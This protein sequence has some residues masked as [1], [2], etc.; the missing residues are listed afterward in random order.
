VE[1]A[2]AALLRLAADP[3]E[4]AAPAR[5]EVARAL[6][7]IGVEPFD[8]LLVPL[9]FDPDVDVAREAV[10]SVGRLERNPALFIAPLVTLLRHRLLKKDARAVLVAYGDAVV[11][12]L[13]HFLRDPHEDVWVRRHVPATL[14]QLPGSRALD[15]LLDTLSDGDGFLRYKAITAIEALHR[16]RPGLAIRR[17]PVETL[18]LG[19]SLRYFEALTLH[20]NLVRQL[21]GGDVPL[22][23]RALDEKQQRARAR[24]FRLLGLLYAQA[25]ISTAWV[26]LERG[27]VRRR[28]SASEYLDNVLKGPLRTRVLLMVDDMPADE[29]IRRVNVLF[30]TRPRDVDDTLAQLVHDEDD[31][32]AA[33]AIHLAAARGPG[34]LADDL[35]YVASHRGDSYAGEA[36]TWALATP[37]GAVGA[38]RLQPLPVV[39]LA[40]RLKRVALFDYVSVDELFR[41][42]GTA[43]Q[44]RYDRG[45]V[46]CP[47]G[48]PPDALQFLL[49]GEATDDAGTAL[50]APALVGFDAMVTRTPVAAEVRAADCAVT[51]SL[52]HD[53]FVTVL[54]DNVEIAHGFFRMLLDARGR[55]AV[56]V[57]P[58]ELP[59]AIRRRGGDPLQPTDALLLLQACPLLAGATPAQLMRVATLARQATLVPGVPVVRESDEAAIHIVVSGALLVDRRGQPPAAAHP[60]DA[61]GMY[62]TLARGHAAAT[63]TAATAGTALRITGRDLFDT[64]ADD[65]DLLERL[66]GA[67]VGS[68]PPAELESAP[69]LGDGSLV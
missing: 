38:D 32:I 41:I 65:V 22:V 4:S 8:Q 11:E 37:L 23:V 47:G 12:P 69:R 18:A 34:P 1:A 2:H 68:A 17:E 27:D 13:A 16:A 39:E 55:A 57:V 19:E 24:V 62:D 63:V 53:E 51:L 7:R 26:A 20:A 48:R 50:R 42:A 52:T 35:R 28:A 44:I 66:L 40:H 10:R 9:L 60:G 45:R 25:D 67:C 64:L 33:A 15:A 36:A 49:S 46:L 5:R 56:D 61:V 43:R 21:E 3:R 59:D 29:R 6:G 54:S 14:A 58:G 31:V 30:R